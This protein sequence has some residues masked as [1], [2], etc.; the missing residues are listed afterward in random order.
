MTDQ[1]ALTSYCFGHVGHP[2]GFIAF[3][4]DCPCSNK[5]VILSGKAYGRRPGV[6]RDNH[7]LIGLVL[8]RISLALPVPSLHTLSILRASYL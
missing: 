5:I 7:D 8:R 2:P 3:A 6:D 1:S 4:R